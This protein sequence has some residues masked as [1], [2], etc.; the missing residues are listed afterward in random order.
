M[1]ILMSLYNLNLYF[2]MELENASCE[3][4]QVSRTSD[5]PWQINQMFDH[6][7]N[8]GLSWFGINL[9]VSFHG[10]TQ[11]MF[12]NLAEFSHQADLEIC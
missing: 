11:N 7:V 10:I 6:G 4:L 1:P 5:Y 8:E 2:P 9:M 3:F 12:C